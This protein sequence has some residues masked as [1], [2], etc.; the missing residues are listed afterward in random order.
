MLFNAPLACKLFTDVNSGY[1]HQYLR[2]S[3]FVFALHP[4]TMCLQI[5]LNPAFACTNFNPNLHQMRYSATNQHE[6]NL[7]GRGYLTSRS[8]VVP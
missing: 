3:Y 1:I 8:L 7:T 4:I 6:V 2:H 5:H